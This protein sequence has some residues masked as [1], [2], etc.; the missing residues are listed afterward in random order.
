MADVIIV[1][2][3]PAGYSAALFTSKYGLDTVV[4]DTDD[5]KMHSAYLWNY[6]GIQEM[7]GSDFLNVA[8]EQV[9]EYGTE[10]RKEKITSA[11]VAEAGFTVETEGGA[12]ESAPYLVVA[13]GLNNDLLKNLGVEM[14]GKEAKVG[15]NGETSIDNLYAVGW[16]SRNQ[17]QAIISAGDGAAAALHLI[18]QVEGKP[19]HDFDVPPSD[20]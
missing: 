12:S 13:T 10:I 1:G 3:G 8:R 7:H 2:G 18:A 6:L 19:Y 11:A 5:S 4:Y 20:A 14:E 16:T 17:S 15:H 9:E